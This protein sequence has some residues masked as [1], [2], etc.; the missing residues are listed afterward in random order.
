MVVGNSKETLKGKSTKATN[1][2]KTLSV[3]STSSVKNKEKTTIDKKQPCP[4]A[5]GVLI[6][7]KSKYETPPFLFTFKIFN[8]NAHNC[9]VD[10]GA[11][12]NGM[13]YSICKKLNVETQMRKSNIIQLDISH[14][15]FLGEIKYVLIHLASS[16]KVHQTIDIIVMNIPEAYGVILSTDWS[17]KL[18]GY[19][20]IDCSH[21]W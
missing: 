1:I 4:K 3:E 10:S 8:Q 7:R 2:F 17:A 18:N 16:S 13:P 5:D 14:V 6:G 21:L 9:L 12:S 20:T 11:S 15:K 19:F